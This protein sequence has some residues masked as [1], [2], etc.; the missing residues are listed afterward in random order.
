MPLSKD[1]ALAHLNKQIS[2][3]EHLQKAQKFSPAFE[4]WRRDTEVVIAKSFGES[5]KQIQDFSAIHYSLMAFTDVTPD[6]EFQRAYVNGL[7]SAQAV[8]QSL[9]SEIEQFWES[10]S[11]DT[12]PNAI[13]IIRRLVYRFHIAARQLRSRHG[14]Q[15]TLTVKNE[16]DAQ[17]LFHVF[18]KL[19][20]DDIRSEEYVPS[21]AGG[22]SRMDFLL[23]K[24]QIV[25]EL[26]KTRKDL[27]EKEIGAQLIIDIARYKAHQDCKT[28]VCFVYDPEGV[29][30]NPAGL[31]KDLSWSKD[32]FSVETLIYPR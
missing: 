25:V 1:K 30:G 5:S 10:N 20:F 32:G 28:L 9:V 19:H 23:K 2:E 17:D 27:G 16:Y 6:S 18:L 11:Q 8:L 15:P 14:G 26:K 24:E 29:I 21:Y 7:N 12:N 4:K 13:V 22:N 3:I 31:E